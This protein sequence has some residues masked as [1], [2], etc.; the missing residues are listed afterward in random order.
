[1]GKNEQGR[2]F[3]WLPFEDPADKLESYELFARRSRC[4]AASCAVIDD[5]ACSSLTAAQAFYTHA[6]FIQSQDLTPPV[7]LR[8]SLKLPAGY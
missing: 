1:L 3:S 5:D 7:C 6:G 2:W 8:L 4:R